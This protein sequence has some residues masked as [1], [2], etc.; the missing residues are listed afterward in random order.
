MAVKELIGVVVSDKTETTK[1]VAVKQ[2]V[3]HKV[4][5]KV[6]TQTKRY[7]VHDISCNAKMGDKVQIRE[8]RPI[9]KTKRWSLMCVLEK[10]ST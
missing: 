8:T 9:S 7:A 1:I 5:K 3:A 2:K 4:Y 6:I 10:S